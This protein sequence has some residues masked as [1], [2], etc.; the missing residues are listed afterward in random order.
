MLAVVKYFANTIHA[1]HSFVPFLNSYYVPVPPLYVKCTCV[2]VCVCVC[3][4]VSREDRYF[5]ISGLYNKRHIFFPVLIQEVPSITQRCW[6]L[7]LM[8]VLN[9]I[10]GVSLVIGMNIFCSIR[11]VT[12]K[13]VIRRMDCSNH[14]YCSLVNFG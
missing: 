9:R 14:W 11:R 12:C 10:F 7:R 13:L 4:R 1:C 8:P 2:C 3:A 6:T 5:V